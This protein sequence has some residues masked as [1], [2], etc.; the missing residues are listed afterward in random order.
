MSRR[1]S[2]LPARFGLLPKMIT[3]VDEEGWRKLDGEFWLEE[4][5]WPL[6]KNEE[7]AWYGG[8]SYRERAKAEW[9]SARFVRY[10]GDS[11]RAELSF[12]GMDW[13]IV[14]DGEN[15]ASA[16]GCPYVVPTAGWW[17]HDKVS[18]RWDRMEGI[19]VEYG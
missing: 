6:R 9:Q 7:A 4:D 17:F 16:G 5:V 12:W 2:K 18:N 19:R 13:Y 3:F 1:S 11:G 10:G 15:V 8:A 14:I